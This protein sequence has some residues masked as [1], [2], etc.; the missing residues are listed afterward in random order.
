[1]VN[2]TTVPAV[3]EAV[4]KALLDGYQATVH[5]SYIVSYHIISC[6]LSLNDFHTWVTSIGHRSVRACST[7]SPLLPLNHLSQFISRP[8][9]QAFDYVH[10][11]P[12]EIRLIWPS[13]W[14]VPKA[15][16]FVLRY[17]VFVNNILAVLYN[18]P[19]DR[20]PEQCERAFQRVAYSTPLVTVGAEAILFLRVYAFSGRSHAM[21]V[22]LVIQF[23]SAKFVDM[24]FHNVS[25]M[26]VEGR[27]NFLGG[28]CVLLLCGVVIV[29]GL[30]ICIA[31]K[32]RRGSVLRAG[33]TGLSTVLFRDGVIYFI[34]LG[35]L[36]S[37]NIFV[38]FASPEGYKLLFTQLTINMHSVLSTRMLLHLREWAE[39]DQYGSVLDTD[40][41]HSLTPMQIEYG[42]ETDWSFMKSDEVNEWAWVRPSRKGDEKESCTLRRADS[43]IELDNR[44]PRSVKNEVG[45]LGETR[46][47]MDLISSRDGY[48]GRVCIADAYPSRKSSSSLPEGSEYAVKRKESW[49]KIVVHV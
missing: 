1:M 22:Y 40:A 8:I 11:L 14:S 3:E 35:T 2:A 17:Y 48:E 24:P 19:K 37:A 18:D 33:R 47:S 7:P 32:R 26:P 4:L 36:L 46:T 30:M 21:L 34:V 41:G 10:T 6:P 39:H 49:T 9:S 31:V 43:P 23:L 13:V 29:M 27:S 5:T 28:V 45:T 42:G 25:C 15:L 16:F 20:T 12:E 44:T 38:T